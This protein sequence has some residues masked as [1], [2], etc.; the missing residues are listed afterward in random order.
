[1]ERTNKTHTSCM[2]NHL[3][4]FAILMD[5]VDETKSSLLSIFNDNMRIFIY[6]SIAICVLFLI[7]AILTLKIFNGILVKVRD[8]RSSSSVGVV[9]SSNSNI[10]PLAAA[11]NNN[12]NNCG[13][14]GGGGGV[15]Q[16]S[17]LP[18]APVASRILD[19]AN[20]SGSGGMPQQFHHHHHLHTH[21]HHHH[22]IPLSLQSN[23]AAAQDQIVTVPFHINNLRND[24]E[25]INLHDFSV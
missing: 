14:T 12:N 2:C 5:V 3:T 15:G 7:I 23:M 13:V 9:S 16:P 25:N 18:T 17:S 19:V 8:N 21:L 11:N 20:S 22:R 4:N 6:I 24:L 1:M 10:V